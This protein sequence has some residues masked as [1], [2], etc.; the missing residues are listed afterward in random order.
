MH[1]PPCSVDASGCTHFRECSL[2]Q[3]SS[4]PIV[5]PAPTKARPAGPCLKDS[6]SAREAAPIPDTLRCLSARSPPC[7]PTS[8]RPLRT[9]VADTEPVRFG[10]RLE[11]LPLQGWLVNKPGTILMLRTPYDY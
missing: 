9:D 10:E 8:R 2:L 6:S 11:W 1:S 5:R 3:Y 7:A 4:R